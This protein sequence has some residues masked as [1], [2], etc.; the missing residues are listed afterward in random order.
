ML[1]QLARDTPFDDEAERGRMDDGTPFRE[2]GALREGIAEPPD[3]D[4]VG[5]AVL[6]ATGGRN[7]VHTWGLQS[8]IRRE[9]TPFA[10]FAEFA[11]SRYGYCR[12]NSASAGLDR[13]GQIQPCNA[14]A[15]I[16]HGHAADQQKQQFEA[17]VWAVRPLHSQGPSQ[18]L[19]LICRVVQS[20]QPPTVEVV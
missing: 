14:L 3:P 19:R 1:P 5:K 18:P 16:A 12:L 9:Q 2:Y 20:P 7:G 4:T 8:P 15:D 17:P 13:V 10:E 11:E 6:L